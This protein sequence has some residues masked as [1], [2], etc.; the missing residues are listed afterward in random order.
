MCTKIEDSLY[1]HNC[2]SER[3]YMKNEA[4]RGTGEGTSLHEIQV[5]VII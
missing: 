1:R 5:N 4:Q 3:L 2:N